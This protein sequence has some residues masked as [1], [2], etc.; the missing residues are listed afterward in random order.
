MTM[1]L[2]TTAR[3]MLR[4]RS[5]AGGRKAACGKSKRKVALRK[6]DERGSGKS[7]RAFSPQKNRREFSEHKAQE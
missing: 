1:K 2:K 7:R 3:A 5:D 6:S 4:V